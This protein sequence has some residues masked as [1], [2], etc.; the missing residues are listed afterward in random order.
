MKFRLYPLSLAMLCIALLLFFSCTSNIDLPPP[1]DS[2]GSFDV[3]S[4][5]SA[6]TPD[7]LSSSSS[8]PAGL[9]WCLYG[10]ICSAMFSE[11]CSDM[12]GQQ[13]CQL[14]ASFMR[15]SRTGNLA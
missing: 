13:C 3:G 8:L 10:E 2:N 12:G 9:V 14:K 7:D 11:I 4:S 1:P 5:S 15:A 6:V